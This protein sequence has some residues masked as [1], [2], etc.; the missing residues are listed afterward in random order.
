MPGCPAPEKLKPTLFRL[1][2]TAL[3]NIQTQNAS[4]RQKAEQYRAADH[5]LRGTSLDALFGQCDAHVGDAAAVREQLAQDSVLAASVV[6]KVNGSI[7]F[8]SVH[9]RKA[10][11]LS[12]ETAAIDR[13]AGCS[14]GRCAYAGAVGPLACVD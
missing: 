11:Q 3:N 2:A 10:V 13:L 4:N 7:Y 14:T 6:S 9:A 8:A 5:R 12:K 1:T